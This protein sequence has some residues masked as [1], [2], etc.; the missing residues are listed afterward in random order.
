V[1]RK[2]VQEPEQWQWSSFR[3]YKYGE[4]G[5]VRVNDCDIMK[6]SVRKLAT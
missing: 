1:K 2:L 6:R 4:A 3:Y 5:L